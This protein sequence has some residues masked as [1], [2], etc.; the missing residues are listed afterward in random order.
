MKIVSILMLFALPVMGAEN[1]L[2]NGSFDNE[3]NP[4]AGWTVDYEWTGNGVYMD[5]KQRVSILPL[6]DG[7]KTVLRITASQESKVE[8]QLVPFE[9][10]TR[11]RCRLNI[12]GG[13]IVRAYIAGYRW[14]PGVRPHD[15]PHPGELRM[16]YKG[17][18][19][20][21]V[22]S[23]WK[24]ATLEF[25]MRKLS[26]QARRHLKQ[27]RFICVYVWTE[28]W[29]SIDNVSLTRISGK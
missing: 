11:Y 24:S 2:E 16:V 27:V 3:E 26:T 19:F 29:A 18:A 8:S 13:G 17:K 22:N 6:D 25:P 4:Y 23:R 28:K 9:K 12:K 7:R 14:K 10:D 21:D 15:N 1:L 20:T 5:N